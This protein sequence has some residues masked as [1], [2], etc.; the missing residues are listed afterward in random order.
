MSNKSKMLWIDEKEIIKVLSVRTGMDEDLIH[1]MI[2][3]F[4][5]TILHHVMLGY[6]VRINDFFT[7]YKRD[8][9]VEILLDEKVKRHIKKK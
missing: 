5:R 3:F 6:K 9:Q 2:Y 4:E 1:T 8:N 7:I